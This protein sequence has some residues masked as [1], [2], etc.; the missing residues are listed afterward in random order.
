MF[1]LQISQLNCAS[2]CI[3]CVIKLMHIL[4]QTSFVLVKKTTYRF[5]SWL[6]FRHQVNNPISWVHWKK[7]S[8]ITE[9]FCEFLGI[10]HA[11]ALAKSTL[12]A[13]PCLSVAFILRTRQHT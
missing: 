1:R 4:G 8:P 6:C 9:T 3:R 7:R 5:G 2:L 12:W 11:L 10:L 13:R